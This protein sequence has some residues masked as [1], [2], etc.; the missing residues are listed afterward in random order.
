MKPP[1]QYERWTKEDEQQLVA[2]QS[3][4]I[5]IG[6]TVYGQEVALK[7]RELEAA[8]AHLVGRREKQ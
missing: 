5:S 8:A 2:L 1:P 3:N 4:A 6:E 7:K